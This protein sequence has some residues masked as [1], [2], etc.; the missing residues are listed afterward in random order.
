[1]VY[2]QIINGFRAEMRAANKSGKWTIGNVPD[3]FAQIL[4]R[5]R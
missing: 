1:M 2:F 5:E 4:N 3:S